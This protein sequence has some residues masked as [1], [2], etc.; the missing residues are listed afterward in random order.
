MSG[1]VIL[2]E[3]RSHIGTI[4]INR[5]E[6][7][8]ALSPEAL[9]RVHET[10]R[11]W[12]SSDEVRCVVIT[13]GGQTAFSSGFDLSSVSAGNTT[14]QAGFMEG[15]NPVETALNTVAGYPYP[16]I[17]MLGGYAFGAGLHLAVC[18]DMRIA[19]DD[20]RVGMPPARLGLVYHPEGIRQ[21][22]DVVGVARARE[23]FFTA[24]TYRGR[25]ALEAGLVDRL[26]PAA[27]LVAVTYALADEIAGNAPLSLK[28]TKRIMAMFAERRALTKGQMEEAKA[29]IGEAFASE[30]LKEGH[31]AF[32]EKRKPLF[33]GK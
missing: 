7:R 28:G 17:A 25:E 32:F 33:T 26:V 29:L 24:R 18:C 21:F 16:T 3:V 14:G 15:V 11:Q 9:F 22:M 5:P 30:D 2:S 27:D 4:T 12:G 8:N 20:V 13:G 6:R 10:L 19:V 23:I 31:R 1:K